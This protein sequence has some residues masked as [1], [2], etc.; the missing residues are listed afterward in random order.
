MA[1]LSRISSFF[2]RLSGASGFTYSVLVGLI[3]VFAL[4]AVTDLGA[5]LRCRFSDAATAI[6]SDGS[7]GCGGDDS[8]EIP[9][10]D[11]DEDI[12]ELAMLAPAD[13][14]LSSGEDSGALPVT[15]TL[16]DLSGA[17]G[18]ELVSLTAEIDN[19]ALVADLDGLLVAYAPGT[20]WTLTIT[21][22]TT[23]GTGLI[24]LTATLLAHP[25]VTETATLS[26]TVQVPFTVNE[27]Q[28][29]TLLENPDVPPGVDEVYICGFPSYALPGDVA[30]GMM[31]GMSGMTLP[32]DVATDT[33][34][35]SVSGG[36]LPGDGI[37]TYTGVPGGSLP[38]D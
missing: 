29:P 8:A 28:P 23:G 14:G 16:S 4:F 36:T 38:D 35:I 15:V 5:T 37:G 2:R 12:P 3:A 32:D 25:E 20:G 13:Q 18:P 11:D 26:L 17:P 34:F 7:T 9:D 10:G 33:N 31:L 22:G 1:A 6:S 24:T 21:A 30:P 19:P 27:C